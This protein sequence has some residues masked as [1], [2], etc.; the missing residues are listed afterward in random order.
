VR[1]IVSVTRS[2]SAVT[3]CAAVVWPLLDRAVPVAGLA[4]C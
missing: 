4:G 3:A 1:V 2:G